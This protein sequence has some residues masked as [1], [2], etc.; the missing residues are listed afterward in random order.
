MPSTIWTE[1]YRPQSF[2][3]ILGQK[4]IVTQAKAFIQ[5]KNMPHLFFAGPAGVGKSTLALVIAKELFGE[6]WKMNFLELNSSDDR[7]ID[8]VRDTI[9]EFAKIKALGNVPFKIIFL[10]E[11]D[12]LTKEA[13]HAL[14][15]TMEN[16][17]T[18][19]RFILSANYSS[20]IIDPIQSRCT[21]FRFKPLEKEEIKN[22]LNRIISGEEL[23]I[24]QESKDTIVN[25]SSGDIRKLTNILQSCASV[26][27]K[28]DKDIIYSMLNAADP[29]EISTVLH[30]A[31]QREFTKARDLLLETMLK[32]GLSGLD[33]IKQIVKETITLDNI[34]DEKKLA[35]ID[36]CGEIEFRMVEGSDEFLQLEALLSCYAR[37]D[38]NTFMD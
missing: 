20:K 10:D 29:Q 11:A 16:Y 35:L 3:K 31:V 36:K 25:I 19:T 9:K 7:G 1:K 38:S 32:H 23:E 30:L 12:A 4:T 28:I 6:S 24:D 17:T 8:V 18:T 2:D 27:R 14:R 21:I 5:E 33:I 37:Q 13:Q 15:R 22:Y 34:T 26:S